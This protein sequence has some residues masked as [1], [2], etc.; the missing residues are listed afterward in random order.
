[1]RESEEGQKTR[2]WITS[3]EGCVSGGKGGGGAAAAKLSNRGGTSTFTNGILS[4][5]CLI[6]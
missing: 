1:M 3:S 5:N 2:L 6:F 4:S